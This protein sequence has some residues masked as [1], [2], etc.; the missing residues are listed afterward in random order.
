MQFDICIINFS[1][2]ATTTDTANQKFLYENDSEFSAIPSFFVLPGLLMNMQSGLTASA[3]KHTTFDLTQILHG[4][5]YL[6][7][8]DTLPTDGIL[9]TKGSVFDV[10]DKKSGAVVVIN[11]DSFDQSGRHLIKNQSSIF[12]TGVG[13]FGGKKESIEGVIPTVAAPD[14]APD[15]II[16]YKTTPD[17]AAL[18]RLSGDLNPLH[19]DPSFSAI[20]G[21]KVPILHGLCSFGFSLRAVLKQYANNDSSLFKA[22]KVRFTKPVIP[23]QTLRISMWQNGTRIHFKTTV[24]ETGVDVLT[25]KLFT[26][27]YYYFGDY[28]C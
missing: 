19:I 25:G 28:I 26:F 7:V 14:R 10:M 23:G 16:E 8:F 4:E 15:S 18:Y 20:A 11:T 27:Y 17:Q 12:V 13:N 1:V 5:Q 3:I 6:E 9:T 22:I 21:F 2:G 24:V